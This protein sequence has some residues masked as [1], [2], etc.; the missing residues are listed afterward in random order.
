MSPRPSL[1]PESSDSVTANEFSQQMAASAAAAAAAN[2]AA[3]QQNAGQQN[4][5]KGEP[6]KPPSR[7]G[8]CRVCLKSFKPDDYSKTCYE[9]Q[10][11]VCE[12][13]ASYSKLDEHEDAVSVTFATL[14]VPSNCDTKINFSQPGD[15]VCVDEKWHPECASNRI[16]PIQC[17]KFPCWK[18]YNDDIPM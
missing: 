15:A 10:Q 4:Q 9:C 14:L 8:A 7:A 18:R 2:A 11:R 6:G 1:I 16:R 5:S 13:C 17:W 3:Q 12:D